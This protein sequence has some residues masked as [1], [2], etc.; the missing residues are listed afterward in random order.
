MPTNSL[1]EGNGQATVQV[2]RGRAEDDEGPQLVALRVMVGERQGEWTL[3]ESNELAA[4]DRVLG[5]VASYIDED[6]A[7]EFED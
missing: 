1:T 7:R 2:V 5:S 4:G 6:I 3:V